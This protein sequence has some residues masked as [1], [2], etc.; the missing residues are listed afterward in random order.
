M[1]ED[2]RRMT[3]D[4]RRFRISDCELRIEK[5]P[6]MKEENHESGFGDKWFAVGSVLDLRISCMVP[7]PTESI[8]HRVKA[9]F[10]ISDC[11][12]RM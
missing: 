12:L 10:R 8:E 4:R 1:T 5:K 3:E 7:S 9:T 2:R 6:K 11:G